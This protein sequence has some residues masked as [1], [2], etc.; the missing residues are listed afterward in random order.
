MATRR[1][2]FLIRPQPLL[3]F[4]EEGRCPCDLGITGRVVGITLKDAH[5]VIAVAGCWRRIAVRAGLHGYGT[6]QM[7]DDQA[8]SWMVAGRPGFG[9]FPA[10]MASQVDQRQVGFCSTRT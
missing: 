5:V 8:R 6:Y 2:W 4:D 10:R 7:G 9:G 3:V 1:V